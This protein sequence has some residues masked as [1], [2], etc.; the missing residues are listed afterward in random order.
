MTIDERLDRLTERH[1]A[2]TQTVEILARTT[3][4]HTQQI[5]DIM[6]AAA[7]LL[8]IA[9]VKE[10]RLTRLEGGEQ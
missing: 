5:T 10:Q 7:R 1:E 8:Q 9:Q 2:L 4:E 6:E 3:H